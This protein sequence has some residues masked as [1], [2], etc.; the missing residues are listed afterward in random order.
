[1]RLQLRRDCLGRQ[2]PLDSLGLDLRPDLNLGL[3]LGARIGG[4]GHDLDL[5]RFPMR[6]ER[7]CQRWYRLQRLRRDWQ[8]QRPYHLARHPAWKP[9]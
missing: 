8:R 1:L 4:L 9:A 6:P 3:R 5:R 7:C 2:L